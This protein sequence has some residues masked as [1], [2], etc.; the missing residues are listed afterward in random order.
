[1]ISGRT[2]YQVYVKCWFT[3]WGD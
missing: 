2:Q 3:R 1:M